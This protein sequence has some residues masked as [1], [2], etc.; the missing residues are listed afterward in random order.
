MVRYPEN[1]EE[2]RREVIQKRIKS[3]PLCLMKEDSIPAWADKPMGG[4][5]MFVCISD[6][7]VKYCGSPKKNTFPCEFMERDKCL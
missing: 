1:Y 4:D 3:M 5:C 6:D 7:G 2:A